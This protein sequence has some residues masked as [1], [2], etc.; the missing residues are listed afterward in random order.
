MV[1]VGL[2]LGVRSRGR[3]R[4]RGCID[5]VSYVISCG[6]HKVSRGRARGWA[7]G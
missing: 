3:D 1:G 5:D 2:G 6:R 4:G 7:R